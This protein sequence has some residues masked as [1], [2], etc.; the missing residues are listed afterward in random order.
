MSENDKEDMKSFCEM[1]PFSPECIK[2]IRLND[3]GRLEV[4]IDTES[5][6]Y[7]KES[8]KCLSQWMKQATGLTL[9]VEGSKDIEEKVED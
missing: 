6:H 5:E 2:T 8:L 1:H 7:N 3:E 9:K 4:V